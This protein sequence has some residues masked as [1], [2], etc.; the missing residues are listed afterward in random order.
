VSLSRLKWMSVLIPIVFLAVVDLVR[1]TIQPDLLHGWPGYLLVL[2][3]VLIGALVY[4]DAIFGIVARMQDKS[5]QQNREL[6]ALHEAGVAI[7]RELSIEAVLQ[8]V[9][10]EARALVGARYGAL[11]VL[12]TDGRIEH[13][14]TS[15]ISAEQRVRIGPPPTGHGLLGV[16]I[17][18]GQPLRLPDIGRDPRS[19][20]FPPNHPPMRSLLAVPVPSAGTP[21]GNLYLAEK[22]NADE[23]NPEDEATLTRFATQAGVAI[24][25]A[26]LHRQ[27]RGLAI[28]EERERIAREMHDSLAQVLGYVNTK[29]QAAHELIDAG[30]PVKA[31]IQVAQLAEAARSAYVDV[32]ENILALR[33]S[34][35]PDRPLGEALRDYLGLWQEQSGVAADVTLDLD[36]GG[37]TLSGI[38]EVQLMRIIQEALANVRKHAEATRARIRLAVVDGAI[39]ATVEDNG[40]GFVPGALPE[41]ALPRFGLATM[42][43]R[44]EA[45]GGTLTIESAPGAGTRI[46][47][48]MPL[49]APGLASQG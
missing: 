22:L 20:G 12:G 39:E 18:E 41:T 44:A 31:S 29:A 49:P 9:V 40:A 10:D 45:V 1:H 47:A 16:A 28:T 42:R 23:F 11:S 38:A 33:T 34:A 27:V 7:T 21:I 13:F 4:A 24:T 8:K 6:L 35:S 5:M 32:R 46:I 14:I 17:K 25:N 48:R 36:R 3:F 19:V 26:R 37:G 15:G 30:Q 43:E 2:G